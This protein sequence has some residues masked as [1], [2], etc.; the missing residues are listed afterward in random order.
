M[1]VI[2]L[3]PLCEI[4]SLTS[5]TILT[6]LTYVGNDGNLAVGNR[7]ARADLNKVA[8]LLSG[9][10]IPDSGMTQLESLTLDTMTVCGV[11]QIS[12]IMKQLGIIHKYKEFLNYHGLSQLIENT[13]E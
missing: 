3:T 5:L 7:S 10:P 6:K 2:S 13:P 4:R 11:E 8:R 9:F 1:D 12:R